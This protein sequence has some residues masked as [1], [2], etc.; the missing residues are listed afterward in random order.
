MTPAEITVL[1]PAA[2]RV[3]EGLLA[4]SN[5]ACP[6]MIPVGG[7]PVIHW[8]LTYLRALGFRK[9]A[10]AVARSGMFVEEFVDCAFGQDCE[11]TFIVPSRDGGVGRTIMELADCVTTRGALVVLG[12]THFQFSDPE[13][14]VGHQPFV[15]TH[16]VEDSYRWC[17]VRSDPDGT[18]VELRDKE[19]NLGAPLDAL[20]GVY[21]FPDVDALQRA[22]HATVDAAESTGKRAELAGI[23]E[24]VHRA[25]PIRAVRAGMW[26][27][28]GNA[29]MQARSHQA[30]LQARAFNELKID[31]ILGTITKRSRNSEKFINEINYLRLLPPDLGVLFP[32]VI[33]YST[34]WADPWV[35]MEYYGYPS[36]SEVFL[37]ENVDPGVWERVFGHL[38]AIV[39]TGFGR[40]G[41]PLPAGSIHEMY[42]G[43]TH[44]RLATMKC[45]PELAALVAHQGDVVVNGKPLANLTLLWPKIEAS[46]ARFEST[47]RGAVVHGDLCLSN[48]LYDLRSR[49]CKL[50]DP[51]GS[52]GA[53]GIYGDPRYDVAKLWHSVHGLYDFITNDLFRVSVEGT[54]VELAI[55]AT[56]AHR[57]IEDRFA[58]VF[59]RDAHAR[60]EVQLVT[61][62]LFASMPALHYDKPQ[63]QLAMY[64]RAL[65]L[66]DEYF[67]SETS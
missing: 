54:R 13:I 3:P 52:F 60:S 40:H 12:D 19:P 27:D 14:V 31:P 67:T 25:T 37:F 43:K 48:I 45:S 6:A 17:I 57:E 28:C 49:I 41:R 8:T 55:R 29:D 46:V 65:Q 34:D 58:G 22:A 26:L 51:R 38:V 18:I 32:R 36:L 33:G 2:G 44:A 59:F 53:V 16:A 66:F 30:L 47:T 24:R 21:G 63:R 42:V 56:A 1:I 62:L 7:R 64:A 4:L 23:L 9:F 5:I 10:I 35:E 61:A 11:F 20:I 50:I 15:L 39:E